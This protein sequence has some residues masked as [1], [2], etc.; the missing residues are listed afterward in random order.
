MYRPKLEQQ[1]NVPA[2]TGATKEC[3][4]RSWSNR[5]MYMPK[6][7]KQKNVFMT[8]AQQK[9]VPADTG[10]TQNVPADT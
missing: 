5:R 1:K 6:V 8:L 3:T 2:D 10:V 7:E 9:I 4:G